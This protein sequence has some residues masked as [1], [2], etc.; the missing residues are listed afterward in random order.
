MVIERTG[1]RA[2]FPR[3]EREL[4]E[5]FQ[6][7]QEEMRSQYLIVYEPSDQKRDGSFRTI[8]IQMTNQQL[9]KD[10]IKITHRPGYFAKTGQKK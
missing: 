1:G 6:Q 10:K 5:A 3:D 2:Y 8:E 9:I 4:R 7:I